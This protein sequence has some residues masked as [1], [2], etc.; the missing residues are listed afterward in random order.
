MEPGSE[1][2]NV[3]NKD[4]VI[5]RMK[6]AVA[7]KQFGQED[8]LCSLIADVMLFLPL[9]HYFIDFNSCFSARCLTSLLPC[10]HA[11]KSA[12]RTQ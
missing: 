2:M 8:I 10:R 12:P 4:E 6:A 11:F 9:Y 1:T 3:R 5:Y 7:S